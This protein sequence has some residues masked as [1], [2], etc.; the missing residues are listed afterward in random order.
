MNEN[1]VNAEEAAKEYGLYLKVVTSVSSFENYNSFFNIFS[2]S[3]EPCRRIAILT[4]EK[5]IEEVYEENPGE[6]IIESSIIGGNIWLKEYTLTTNPKNIDLSELVVKKD[7]L[8][9]FLKDNN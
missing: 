3:D 7:I 4:S 5:D 1:Y 2:E 6:N 9:E 8:N